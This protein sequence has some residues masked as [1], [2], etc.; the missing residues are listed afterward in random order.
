MLLTERLVLPSGRTSK[1]SCPPVHQPVAFIHQLTYKCTRSLTMPTRVGCK[2]RLIFWVGCI[3]VRKISNRF[4]T[5]LGR[6]FWIHA[7]SCIVRLEILLLIG[8]VG[9]IF[10]ECATK[11]VD[12]RGRSR[13]RAPS[14]PERWLDIWNM[15]ITAQKQSHK[16]WN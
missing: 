7:I 2:R 12:V 14:R 6:P 1:F 13:L 15:R 3:L 16:M 10:W 9:Q 8:F 5:Y 4:I 11:L